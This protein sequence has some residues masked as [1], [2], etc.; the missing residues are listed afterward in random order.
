MR[1]ASGAVL[2]PVVWSERTVSRGA[3]RA[4]LDLYAQREKSDQAKPAIQD[5][6]WKLQMVLELINVEFKTVLL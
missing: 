2:S 1:G 4:S 6:K 5:G 3:L